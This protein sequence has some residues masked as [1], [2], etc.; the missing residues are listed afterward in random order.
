MYG[1][2]GTV[3]HFT[4]DPWHFTEP[5]GETQWAMW[6]M[7]MAWCAQHYWEHYLF[8][9]DKSYLEKSGYPVMKEAAEFCLNYLVENPKTK[10]LVSGPSISPENTF[11][12]KEGAS[13]TM[14]MGPTMDHMIIR[15]LFRN[16]IEASKLLNRDDDIQEGAR[17]NISKIIANRNRKRWSHYGMDRRV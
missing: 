16:T 15:D 1:V 6:P 17:K 2:A 12:T 9:G 13:A 11:K 14:V 3:A 4:T 7:G 8:A 5:Y 10:K